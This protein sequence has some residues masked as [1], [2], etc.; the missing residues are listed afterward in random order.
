ME[1]LYHVSSSL[2]MICNLF[3]MQIKACF[4]QVWLYFRGLTHRKHSSQFTFSAAFYLKKQKN[5]KAVQKQRCRDRQTETDRLTCWRFPGQSGRRCCLM[6]FG[7]C[8]RS[9]W[10]ESLRD[11][12]SLY[13]APFYMFPAQKTGDVDTHICNDCI[14]LSWSHLHP[15][16]KNQVQQLVILQYLTVM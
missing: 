10:L 9:V 5:S 14:F 16:D 3:K 4:V 6:R 11:V 2:N 13:N 1:H 7:L 12:L 15:A 8:V